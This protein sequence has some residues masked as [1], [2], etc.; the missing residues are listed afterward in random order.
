MPYCPNCKVMLAPGSK[1]CPLCLGASA[2]SPEAV[3]QVPVSIPPEVRNVEESEKLSPAEQR[4]MVFEL[5]CASF[6]MI[7]VV[8]IATDIALVHCITW[9]RYSSLVLVMVW[10]FS[11][12]PLL[13]WGRPFLIYAVLGPALFLAVFLWGAFSGNFSWFLPLG[14]PVIFFVE[15]AVIPA[16][17]LVS[18][19]RRKGLNMVGTILAAA[20]YLC[21]GVDGTIMRYLH[22]TVYL[23][24]SIVV[25]MSVIPVSGY[26][27]YLHYRVT[28]QA[29]LRKLFRL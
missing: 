8:S 16:F 6:G 22:G 29:S 4:F 5:L 20:G 28:K 13:L 18:V 27:F 17:V 12:I 26:F 2:D 19:Q 11:A 24:W 21:A 9:S 3:S 1:F 25:I 14:L 10:L 23:S 15:S 7:L